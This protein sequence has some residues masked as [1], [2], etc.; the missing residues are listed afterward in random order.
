[1]KDKIKYG[2]IGTSTIATVVLGWIYIPII[3]G[4]IFLAIMAYLAFV[5]IADVTEDLLS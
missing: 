1:M 3:T 5:C 2:L 4:C